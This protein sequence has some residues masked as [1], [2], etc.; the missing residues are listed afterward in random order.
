MGHR[1]DILQPIPPLSRHE[2]EWAESGMGRRAVERSGHAAFDWNDQR[3]LDREMGTSTAVYGRGNS[4]RGGLSA[5]P[6][7]V[8]G[9]GWGVC[10]R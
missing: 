1:D 9:F 10:G 6:R 8:W 7:V 5:A 2:Q 4:R 3:S